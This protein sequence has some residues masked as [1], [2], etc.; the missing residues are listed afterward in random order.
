MGGGTREGTL[1]PIGVAANSLLTN[2]S[3]ARI[4]RS[5]ASKG[6]LLPLNVSNGIEQA[7]RCDF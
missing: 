3:L 5:E 4:A 6:F 7:C 1:Y 2:L